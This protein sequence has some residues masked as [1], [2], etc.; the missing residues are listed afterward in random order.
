MHRCIDTSQNTDQG[1]LLCELGNGR[2]DVAVTSLLHQISQLPLF[3]ET[4]S[5]LIARSCEK[6]LDQKPFVILTACCCTPASVARFQK[7]EI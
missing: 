2:E 1:S 7:L 5:F 3:R 4:Q 6:C